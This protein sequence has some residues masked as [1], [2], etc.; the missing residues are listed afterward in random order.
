[1]TLQKFKENFFVLEWLKP[2]T[3]FEEEKDPMTQ[4]FYR[5][6]GLDYLYFQRPGTAYGK[7][8]FQKEA[9]FGNQT[10]QNF[11]TQAPFELSK[12]K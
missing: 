6:E 9:G 11:F 4:S 2:K 8:S 5:N 3:G 12:T 1:M 7:E 10:R